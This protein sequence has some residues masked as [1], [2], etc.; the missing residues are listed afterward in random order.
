M[1]FRLFLGLPL[2][3]LGAVAP[4]LVVVGAL[5]RFVLAIGA[6]ALLLSTAGISSS[7][8]D[9]KG[10]PDLDLDLILGVVMSLFSKLLAL[11]S[12]LE[13]SF[14]GDGL[15]SSLVAGLVIVVVLVVVFPRGGKSSVFG[16]SIGE[17][18]P[19]L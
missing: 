14:I 8:S 7:A 5:S 1:G 9:L 11:D 16:A 18:P 19:T 12:E 3:L 6:I 4:R 10:I 15:R 13:K 2:P 17:C